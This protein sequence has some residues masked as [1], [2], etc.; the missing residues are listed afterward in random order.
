MTNEMVGRIRGCADVFIINELFQN[1]FNIIDNHINDVTQ[2]NNG[3][4]STCIIAALE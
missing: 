3:T 2:Q 4:F 1:A